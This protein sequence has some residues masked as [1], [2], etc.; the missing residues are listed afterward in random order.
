MTTVLNHVR[1]LIERLAG[2]PIC[3]ECVTKKLGLSWTSQ[4]NVAM[5]EL[6][7]TS[8]FERYIDVCSLCGGDRK[9]TRQVRR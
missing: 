1:T 7:A 9:V 6:V 4:A 8:G 3:D 5:R 2:E